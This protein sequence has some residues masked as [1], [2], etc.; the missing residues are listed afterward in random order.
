MKK[1]IIDF[2]TINEMDCAPFSET[3]EYAFHYNIIPID[4]SSKAI[5]YFIRV[6]I[7][8][9]TITS[10]EKPQW[11]V[12]N[13]INIRSL[14]VKCSMEYVKRKLKDGSLTSVN[15]ETSIVLI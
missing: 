9:R 6:N 8:D 12:G 7:A 1:V 14:L 13:T 3:I 15:P 2:S 5:T 10:W 4:G 11:D